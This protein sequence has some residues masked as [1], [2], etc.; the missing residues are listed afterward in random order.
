[1]LDD[2]YVK[3]VE[4]R[5]KGKCFIIRYADDFIIGCEL[6]SDARRIMDVLPKKVQPIWP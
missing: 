3:E 6:K 2:W 1:V 5:M 4:P